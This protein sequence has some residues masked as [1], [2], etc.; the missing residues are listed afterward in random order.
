MD[1][2]RLKRI[3]RFL[4]T[5]YAGLSTWRMF[6]T[7]KPDV[8]RTYA[9]WT[10]SHL[11]IDMMRRSGLLSSETL[12][13]PPLT[14]TKRVHMAGNAV[15]QAWIGGLNVRLMALA[16]ADQYER[17]RRSKDE[18][19]ALKNVIDKWKRTKGIRRLSL[20]WLLRVL[21]PVRLKRASYPKYMA[22]TAAKLLAS[23]LRPSETKALPM[24]GRLVMY[25]ILGG[26]PLTAAVIVS[27]PSYRF[28]FPRRIR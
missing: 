10:A 9:L 17:E 21:R 5:V 19:R 22:L 12:P 26:L 2:R 15:S 1:K 7:A 14:L 6:K 4:S 11:A 20:L 16:W 28:L 25:L 3:V 13:S 8:R 24:P 27:D 18:E 23:L